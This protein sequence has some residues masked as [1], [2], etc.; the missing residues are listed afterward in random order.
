MENESK[1]ILPS[2]A[3][4]SLY[5]RVK[6]TYVEKR[7]I[8]GKPITF[9]R[10]KMLLEDIITNNRPVDNYIVASV[11]LGSKKLFFASLAENAAVNGPGEGFNNLD[12]AQLAAKLG[13]KKMIRLITKI[14]GVRLDS[15]YYCDLGRKP[16]S[17]IAL[18]YEKYGFLSELDR[19][20]VN[21]KKERD[22]YEGLP[23]TQYA[24][25][26]FGIEKAK[27]AFSELGKLRVDLKTKDDQENPL[28]HNFYQGFSGFDQS[29]IEIFTYLIKNHSELLSEKNKQGMDIL[30][31]LAKQDFTKAHEDHKVFTKVIIAYA[32]NKTLNHFALVAK[33]V[34]NYG[35]LKEIRCAWKKDP[36]SIYINISNKSTNHTLG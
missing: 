13:R 27:K 1:N 21:L 14:P 35:L 8:M 18:E 2:H 20:G 28:M 16:P 30:G 34:E 36:S 12:S 5:E 11:Y 31:I 29:K 9:E 7:R 15:E 17:F 26:S 32:D 24:A 3:L 10:T 4:K 23:L 33:K 6:E 19:L 22:N 25:A